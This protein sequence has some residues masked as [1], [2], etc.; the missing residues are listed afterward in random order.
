MGNSDVYVVGAFMTPF[1]RFAEKT[2]KELTAEAVRGALKD[3]GWES[4]DRLESA[5]F[6]S[7]A[8]HLFSQTNVRGQS[9]LAPLV[10]EKVLPSNLPIV[11]VEAACATGAAAFQTA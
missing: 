7:C 9:A 11:N 8:M 10:A 1:G 2:H 6:G 5:V 4:G 3:A